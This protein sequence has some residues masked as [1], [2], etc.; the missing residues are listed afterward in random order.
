MV[1]FGSMNFVAM[2][3]AALAT[4]VLGAL[5]Y[6]PILFGDAW[7]NAI[8]KSREELGSP[9]TPLVGS[10]LAAIISAVAMEGLIV[11]IGA[12][13]IGAGV[14]VG[15]SVGL[16]LVATAMLSDNLF[17]GWGMRLYAIQVGYRVSYLLI[18]GAILGGWPR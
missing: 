11:A 3:V 6:S 16:G 17:C 5:W 8:G 9:T 18:I 10:M 1:D 13:S 15:A 12:Y 14:A 7:L 4:M 2:G